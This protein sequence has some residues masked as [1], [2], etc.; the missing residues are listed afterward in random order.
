[1]DL[2]LRQIRFNAIGQPSNLSHLGTQGS[3][4]G[5]N[6]LGGGSTLGPTGDR[7]FVRAVLQ[8]EVGQLR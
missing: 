2:F 7:L 5:H 1:M 8:G 4:T 3:R 6:F